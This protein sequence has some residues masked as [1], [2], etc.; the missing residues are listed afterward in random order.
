MRHFLCKILFTAAFSTLALTGCAAIA[1]AKVFDADHYHL[2]NGM[3]IVV[4][5]NHRAPVVTHM[6]W[7]K[8]GAGDEK[9]GHSGIAHFMEHL[10]FKG[11]GNDVFG[12]IEAGKFSKIIKSLGGRDNAFTSWDYTAYFQSVAK[13]HLGQVMRMEAGRMVGFSPDESHINSEREVILEERRQRTDNSPE[14]Q[15]S[16]TLYARA[17][18]NHPYGT[19][20]IGWKHEMETLSRDDALDWHAHHYAPNNA[21]L[22]V[23]GDVTGPQVY[24]MARH[25]YGTLPPRDVPEQ[26]RVSAPPLVGKTIVDF[27]DIRLKEPAVQRL[28]RVPSFA[29]DHKT[30][31]A[32]QVLQEI[33]SGGQTARLY[34]ALVKDQKIASGAGMSYNSDALN[35]TA[36]WLYA[37]PLPGIAPE[38]LDAA[39]ESEIRVLAKNGLRE[40]ELGEA[41]QRMQDAA[42]Y[43]RD[44]LQGP[45][46]II[47]RALTTGSSL[48]DIENW[49]DQ[50]AAI[51]EGDI[52]K[53]AQQYILDNPNYVTGYMR[54]K[55]ED[56]TPEDAQ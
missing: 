8:T 50:I 6:V 28:Y 11:S 30:S 20:I 24:A 47:G 37:V 19:P 12:Q 38:T 21:I 17:F 40:G 4:V 14:A 18:V 48:D 2:E 46:M 49:P 27:E 13:E 35:D 56:N 31:L 10:M 22:V 52:I 41:I 36:L 55:T 43:A 7:Y 32:L 44:S 51:N 26:S 45:A 54:P 5:P 23:S 34:Q 39:L 15:F 16:E 1:M 33:M 25:I 9:T 3:E 29:T 42:I 53:A